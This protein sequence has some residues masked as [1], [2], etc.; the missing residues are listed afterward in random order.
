MCVQVSK[1]GWKQRH[2]DPRPDQLTSITPAPEAGLNHLEELTFKSFKWWLFSFLPD[3]MNFCSDKRLDSIFSLLSD[4]VVHC[5]RV[6]SVQT[7]SIS[8]AGG[9][10]SHHQAN[11][12]NTNTMQTE[13]LLHVPR[14]MPSQ[15]IITTDRGQGFTRRPAGMASV[16][17]SGVA[18]E[19]GVSHAPS[20]PPGTRAADQAVLYRGW[21]DHCR[22]TATLQLQ[23]VLPADVSAV[24]RACSTHWCWLLAGLETVSPGAAAHPSAEISSPVRTRS[25]HVATHVTLR[26]AKTI[27]T[28]W[29]FCLTAG[30]RRL[31]LVP[32]CVGA[33]RGWEVPRCQ[34]AASHQSRRAANCYNLEVE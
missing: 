4:P 27:C 25:P 34:S 26:L 29:K 3:T 5:E 10:W 11:T 14:E 31:G 15:A 12:Q 28:H 23:W 18:L 17:Y 24:S 1:S 13:K 8:R 2:G 30:S 33:R 21:R 9:C 32:S 22:T 19:A 6:A 7:P 20:P 16:W